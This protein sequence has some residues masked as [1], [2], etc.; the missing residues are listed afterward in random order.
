MDHGFNK[1]EIHLQLKKSK[2]CFLQLLQCVGLQAQWVNKLKFLHRF[3]HRSQHL[4]V[5]HLVKTDCGV[6]GIMKKMSVIVIHHITNLK[7]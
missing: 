5:L 1:T 4:V 2:V 7:K 3:V 6:G